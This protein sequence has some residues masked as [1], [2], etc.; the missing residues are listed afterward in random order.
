MHVLFIALIFLPILII[1]AITPYITRKTESFGVSIPSELYSNPTIASYRKAYAIQTSIIGSIFFIMAIVLS[2][3]ISKEI[4]AII[5]SVAIFVYMFIGFLVYYQFHKKMKQ[6]K[7]EQNWHQTKKETVVID[8]SFYQKKLTYS[9]RW[10]LIPLF[11]ALIS[12]AYS[13]MNYDKIP[14]QIPMQYDF[15]GEVTRWA[16]KSVGAVINFPLL[17][18]FM[19][20]LFIFINIII[21]RSKQQIDPANPKVS[22][23]QN[24]IF[25]R[26]WSL[27]TIIGATLLVSIFI[28]PQ[29]SF[30]VSVDPTIYFIITMVIIGIIVFG[31]IILSITTGQGGSRVKVVKGNNDEMINRDDD[32]YWKLGVFYFNREDPALFLEKR[33][34]SG[35]TMNFA[36]PLGW[37]ILLAITL[38]PIIIAIITS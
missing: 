1:T 9:N 37:I 38:I 4:W 36:R 8:T 30:F 20:G 33:F 34:G 14:N 28:V 21:A 15:S 24:I 3:I 11:M 19:I 25:R 13:F 17:Q 26:R 31:A 7:A 10:F 12:S 16:E 35:W 27:F 22:M 18:L 5:F 2:D 29:I 32:R 23:E 6:L